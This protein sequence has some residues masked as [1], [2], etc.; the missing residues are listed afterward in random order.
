M[1]LIV[2][3]LGQHGKDTVC[4]ILQSKGYSFRSS[5]DFC[6]HLVI[7]PVLSK[8]YGYKTIEECYMDRV[9][10]REEWYDLICDF[11]KNDPTKLGKLIFENYDIYCGLR[12]VI[13][14][15]ALKKSGLDIVTVWVDATIRLGIT[16]TENSITITR[17]DCD[18]VIN[19]NGSLQ[20]LENRVESLIRILNYLK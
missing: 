10:H 20:D 8:R 16:E 11:N 6:N 17:E 13:E 12:N 5:S 19:N 14:F 2:T 1:K 4:E 18:Y 15:N 9:N 7:F 3:G